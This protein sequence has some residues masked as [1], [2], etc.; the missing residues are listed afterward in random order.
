MD[1][2]L[3]EEQVLHRER[4]IQG[5]DGSHQRL[6]RAPAPHRTRGKFVLEDME[7]RWALALKRLSMRFVQRVLQTRNDANYRTRF[8]TQKPE[9][10]S[11]ARRLD[12]ESL[13]L[14]PAIRFR[15]QRSSGCM[16]HQFQRHDMPRVP[17]LACQRNGEFSSGFDKRRAR[18]RL[19]PSHNRT[20]LRD[21][22]SPDPMRPRVA[23]PRGPSTRIP[24]ASALA[25]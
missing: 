19:V 22:Y 1:S 23:T 8:K 13:C 24:Q 21:S 16:I 14:N 2:V 10:P 4:G 5:G 3:R 11:N 17:K 20:L 25:I 15:Q 18:L 12:T 7:A 9:H 6:S